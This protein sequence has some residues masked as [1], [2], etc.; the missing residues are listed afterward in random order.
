M[1]NAL[2]VDQLSAN[3]QMVSATDSSLPDVDLKGHTVEE[4]AAVANVS[5]NAI[6]K[7]IEM[8]RKQLITE[9]EEQMKTKGMNEQ[10]FVFIQSHL[11]SLKE[12]SSQTRPKPTD[13]TIYFTSSEAT[14]SAPVVTPAEIITKKNVVKKAVI[15]G[16]SK[17]N[18]L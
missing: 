16:G 4:L 17:V 8:R 6:R 5:V 10:D 3:S 15:G 13:T 18:A 1:K 7:A 2:Q 14:T 11:D 12:T 9:R